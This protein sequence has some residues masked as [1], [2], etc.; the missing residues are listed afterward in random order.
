[1]AYSATTVSLKKCKKIILPKK[2]TSILL[3]N[4]LLIVL[5]FRKNNSPYGT[6]IKSPVV[7]VYKWWYFFF[8]LPLFSYAYRVWSRLFVFV[9]EAFE[10]P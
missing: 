6:N 1:M 4:V 5:L 3:L 10:P 8:H 9:S 7:Q 2:C